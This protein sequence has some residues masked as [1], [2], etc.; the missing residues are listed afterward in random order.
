MDDNN[1]GVITTKEINAFNPCPEYD[2]KKIVKAFKELGRKAD[3]ND[4]SQ[5]ITPKQGNYFSIK[6]LNSI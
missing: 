1:D 2:G 4:F 5:A 3:M 6:V